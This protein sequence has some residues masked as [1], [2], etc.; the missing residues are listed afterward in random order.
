MPQRSTDFF[1]EGENVS[2]CLQDLCE[3]QKW[4]QGAFGKV[5]S[6]VLKKSKDIPIAVK[7]FH[8]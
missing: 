1:Y 8:I 4:G 3:V 6:I 7:V 5:F 2:V